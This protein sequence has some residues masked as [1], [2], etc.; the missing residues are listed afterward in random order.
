MKAWLKRS[1]AWL[2]TKLGGY[3]DKEV[4]FSVLAADA[5]EM[6]DDLIDLKENHTTD[7]HVKISRVNELI[8]KY[9]PKALKG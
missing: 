6:R 3:P 1:Q 8:N 2:I 5:N 7:S 4:H 9:T